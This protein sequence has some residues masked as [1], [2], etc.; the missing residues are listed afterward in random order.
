MNE[1]GWF[2]SIMLALCALPQA[3]KSYKDK[4]SKGLDTTFL[5]L[6]S[7]GEILTAIAVYTSPTN[8]VYLF[9]NYGA[10]LIFLSVIWYYKLF[11]LNK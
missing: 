8:L 6:W 4:H 2:G 3:I 10:N 9:V 5:L 11:P 1:I 7:A